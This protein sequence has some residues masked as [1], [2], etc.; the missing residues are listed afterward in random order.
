MMYGVYEGFAI[1]S[2]DV[3]HSFLFGISQKTSVGTTIKGITLL[4]LVFLSDC[5]REFYSWQY[6]FSKC[7]S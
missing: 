6:L 2:S 7:P 5:C 4:K 3:T 1:E